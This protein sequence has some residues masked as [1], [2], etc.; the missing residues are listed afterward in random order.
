VP[1]ILFTRFHPVFLGG[2]NVGS[3]NKPPWTL[4]AKAKYGP[5]DLSRTIK[6]Y[7]TPELKSP[8]FF[9]ILSVVPQRAMLVVKDR[10]PQEIFEKCFLSTWTYSFITHVDISK[11]ENLAKLLSEHFDEAE[12]KE[13]MKLM[14]TKQY[15]DRLTDNT[16]R[17][18]ELGAFGAPWF[19]MTN[20]QG[21]QEPLFGSDRWAYM[22]RFMGVKFDDLKIVDKSRSK[23]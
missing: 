10:H 13:I 5:Y 14:T 20:E 15:K 18:L 3:G 4:P 11:P 8:P 17:A 12:V 19:W 21:E 23:L 16:K 22:F 9:P 6:H 2:I 7:G 1:L